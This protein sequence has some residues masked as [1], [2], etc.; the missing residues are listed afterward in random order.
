MKNKLIFIL[1]VPVMMFQLNGKDVPYFNEKGEM[2]ARKNQERWNE[3]LERAIQMKLGKTRQRE[4]IKIFGS[5]PIKNYAE[6][7]LVELLYVDME[8]EH[9]KSEFKKGVDSEKEVIALSFTFDNR[10]RLI[11]AGVKLHKI[12]AIG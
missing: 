7:G 3:A 12:P 11:K 8:L 9:N 5:S 10:D 2:T 6:Q 4:I 1:I